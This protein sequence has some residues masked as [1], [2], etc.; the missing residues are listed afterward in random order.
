MF[1]RGKDISPYADVRTV[2]VFVLEDLGL[3]TLMPSEPLMPVTVED[4]EDAPLCVGGKEEEEMKKRKW[5]E[6]RP[7]RALFESKYTKG[8]ECL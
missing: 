8:N 1:I 6:M 3:S 5:V 7:H 4:D 2:T